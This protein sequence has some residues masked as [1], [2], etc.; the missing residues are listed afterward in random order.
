MSMRLIRIDPLTLKPMTRL[1]QEVMEA[2]DA[3]PMY[4]PRHDRWRSEIGVEYEKRLEQALA[5]LGKF[6]SPHKAASYIV[7]VIAHL[8]SDI[9]FESESQLR[10][11][12]T[13]RTPD[14]LLS[15][16]MGVR[17]P[18]K[19]ES[20]DGWKVVCWIDSKVRRIITLIV[21]IFF[22]NTTLSL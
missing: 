20:D 10:E 1:A 16:P 18:K 4:G 13:P 15:C 6:A 8:C 22:S 12:G 14:V 17:V 7:R 5:A 11:R 19:N 2:I 9:P 3:D 21:F